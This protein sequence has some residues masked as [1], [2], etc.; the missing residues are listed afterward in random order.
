MALREDD[1]LGSVED[2]MVDEV[3]DQ[4]RCLGVSGRGVV[5]DLLDGLV[6]A[7]GSTPG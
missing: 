7:G 2:L 4:E 6:S 5:P 1:L 3:F